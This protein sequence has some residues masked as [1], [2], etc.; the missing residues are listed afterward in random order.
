MTKICT[1]CKI[2][3]SL[4]DFYND[5]ASK[6]KKHSNCKVCDLQ[7]SK[8]WK[9]NNANQVI[10]YRKQWSENNKEHIKQYGK[11]W[12]AKNKEYK[13]SIDKVMRQQNKKRIAL[14][15]R[16]WCQKNRQR[17]NDYRKN[18]WQ[19]DIEYRLKGVLRSRF[20]SAL[21]RNAKTD[22]AIKLLGCPVPEFKQFFESKFQY[23]WTW[24]NWGKVWEIDHIRPLSSF[25]LTNP[26]E[27]KKAFHYSNLQPLS[28]TEN[29]SKN[30]KWTT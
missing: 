1:K 19:T 20:Y 14:S 12:Y 11:Q 16:L 9:L 30:D 21:R 26:E 5:N 6:N 8:Q 2:K 7:A 15:N 24:G 18:R 10:A 22:S 28:I 17:I 3:K 29:R 23:D 27:L 25:D 13:A 4:N